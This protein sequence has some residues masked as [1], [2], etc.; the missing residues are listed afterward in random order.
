MF[1]MKYNEK[2]LKFNNE[3][4]IND[5]ILKDFKSDIKSENEF[6]MKKLMKKN[7]MFIDNNLILTLIV[8]SELKCMKELKIINSLL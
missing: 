1:L 3:I 7:K 8:N 5:K 4:L 2:N 6:N